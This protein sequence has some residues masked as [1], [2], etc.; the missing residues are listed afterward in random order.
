MK[1]Y[2]TPAFWANY[3]FA[4]ENMPLVWDFAP[5]ES[6][7][8]EVVRCVFLNAATYSTFED[9]AQVGNK[10][11][12]AV[13]ASGSAL[14]ISASPRW[15]VAKDENGTPQIW[16]N[17]MCQSAVA[18]TNAVAE[19]QNQIDVM[20]GATPAKKDPLS[21]QLSKWGLMDTG[22]PKAIDADIKNNLRK[23]GV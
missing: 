2:E 16:I 15:V 22:A 20:T 11:V 10:A 1:K 13:V 12:T 3:G 23:W 18:Y 19:A 17:A 7:Q 6:G 4:P 9:L 5:A 8:K 21:E 14:V